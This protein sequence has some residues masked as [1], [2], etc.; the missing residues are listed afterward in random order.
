MSSIFDG[1]TVERV[2]KGMNDEYFDI[3]FTDG[4]VL[5][6]DIKDGKLHFTTFQNNS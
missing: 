5:K 4:T 6:I 3:W 1:R 2:C